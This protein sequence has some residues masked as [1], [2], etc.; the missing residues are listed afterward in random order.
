[1][2]EFELIQLSN[3]TYY[4]SSRSNIG[5]YEENG[6]A[7]LI[8]SG[9]DKEAG[10]RAMK[11]IRQKGWDVVR[12]INTHSNA[13]HIGG[14]AFIQK[15]TSCGNSCYRNGGS[16]LSPH[17]GALEPFFGR[18]PEYLQSQA[19]GTIS[20]WAR[21]PRLPDIIGRRGP[22]PALRL[23]N[24]VPLRAGNTSSLKGTGGL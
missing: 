4:I 12:I 1:M 16:G 2:A 19:F 18:R 10:R 20:L 23:W 5:I 17:P 6:N 24:A 9:I 14:N 15:L 7:I 8:D 13:D 22:I 3:H 21:F 11:L